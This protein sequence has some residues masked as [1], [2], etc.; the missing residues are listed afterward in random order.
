MVQQV[1]TFLMFPGCAE[2]AVRFYEGLFPEARIEGLERFTPTDSGPAGKVKQAVL[3]LGG[4]RLIAF[5][6]PVKHEFGMTPAISL[7]VECEN[8]EEL[9]RIATA[10]GEGGTVL[11]PADSYDFAVRFTWLNDRFGLSWQL[12]FERS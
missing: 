9:D 1:S 7:F 2:E 12:C 6:S 5:D 11:M 3:V 4:H 8:A 10:L